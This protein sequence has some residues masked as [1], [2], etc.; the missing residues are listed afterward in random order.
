MPDPCHTGPELP[1][2]VPHQGDQTVDQISEVVSVSVH[3]LAY[4]VQKSDRILALLPVWHSLPIH[5]LK[6]K[7]RLSFPHSVLVVGVVPS[8]LVEALF[9]L[10]VAFSLLVVVSYLHL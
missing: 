8:H 3:H 10:V 4:L 9:L 1:R 7:K 5:C 2:T 6:L